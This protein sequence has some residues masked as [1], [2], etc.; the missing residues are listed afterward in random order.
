M[1]NPLN[2]ISKFIKSGNKKELDRIGKIVDQINLLE[3]SIKKLKD[4]YKEIG[5]E[6]E[7]ELYEED[8]SNLDRSLKGDIAKQI[9][10]F[11]GLTK[12]DGK[13]DRLKKHMDRFLVLNE[14]IDQL[15]DYLKLESINELK[16][17][18]LFRQTVPVSYDNSESD[19]PVTV[20]FFDELNV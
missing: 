1:L 13:P 19:I 20:G 9:Y 16:V 15:R 18:L 10:E 6:K 3:E 5:K 17:M 8:P 14:N 12:S 11:R 4:K 2:F 7:F